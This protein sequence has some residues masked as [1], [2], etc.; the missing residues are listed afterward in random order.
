MSA[1]YRTLESLAKILQILQKK[2]QKFQFPRLFENID[3][4]NLR[5]F[6]K[7]FKLKSSSK[8]MRSLSAGNCYSITWK[9][10]S[11]STSSEQFL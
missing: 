11:N 1:K 2:S 4:I 8:A 3:S 10:Y 5:Q 6:Q 7:S 9:S